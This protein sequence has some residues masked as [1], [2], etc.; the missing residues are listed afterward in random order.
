M[1][2]R[3]AI[4][5][6]VLA[7]LSQIDVMYQFSLPWFTDIFQ[8]SITSDKLT[9]ANRPPTNKTTTAAKETVASQK[10]AVTPGPT[11][12]LSQGGTTPTGERG[13]EIEESPQEMEGNV[14]E[15]TDDGKLKELLDSMNNR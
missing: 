4:L 3:A 13:G 12:P 5:Y 10:V 8:R 14:E 15:G 6:F 11:T 9:P 2:K 1:A 7:D